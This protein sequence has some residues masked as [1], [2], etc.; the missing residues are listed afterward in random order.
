MQGQTNLVYIYKHSLGVPTFAQGF[1]LGL[2]TSKC[3]FLSTEG[4]SK[5]LKQQL[6]KYS[7]NSSLFDKLKKK[8]FWGR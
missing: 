7:S 1:L 8:R 2:I 3:W 5:R 4:S 6:D